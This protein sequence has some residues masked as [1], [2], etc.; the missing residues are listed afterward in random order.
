MMLVENA[1]VRE[2]IPS[3]FA[4]LMSPLTSNVDDLLQPGV[5]SLCWSS[6][7][8]EKFVANVYRAVGELEVL[9]TRVNDILEFRVESVLRQMSETELCEIPDEEPKSVDSFL[10]ETE[11]S[12][13]SEL[14]RS[15]CI[16]SL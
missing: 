2:K 13:V 9:V 7:Q 11:V 16:R 12:F 14:Q 3:S 15:E 5:V 1:R 8:I 10:Q 6:T 4:D